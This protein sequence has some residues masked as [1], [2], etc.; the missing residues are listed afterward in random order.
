MTL[1]YIFVDTG[2]CG[3]SLGSRPNYPFLG[4]APL[5]LLRANLYAVHRTYM[6]EAEK[7]V[8]P[9]GRVQSV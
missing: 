8:V 7:T 6:A 4:Q 2:S 9:G 1:D 3:L 5:C